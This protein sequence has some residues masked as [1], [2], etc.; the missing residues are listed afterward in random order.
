MVYLVG[1]GP[2]DPGLI[3]VRG[4]EVIAL[5][6]VIIADR[7]A[8]PRLLERARPDAEKIVRGPRRE[9]D[10]A[11]ISALLVE[12]ARAGK[13]V[14][15][16]KGGDPFL[17][18]RGGE[19][20]QALEQ[21]G[22]AYEVVPGVT[23]A[24]AA[25][26]YAG[27]PLTHR[28]LATQVAFATGH[29]ADKAGEARLDWRALADPSTTAVLYMSVSHLE[30]AMAEL[31]R[32]GRAPETPAAI[33]EAG[34]LPAQRTVVGTIADLPAL[35]RRAGVKPPALTVVGE[36]VRFAAAPSWFERRP[37][38]G[39]QVLVTRPAGQADGTVARLEALGARVHLAP[40]IA[41]A[42]PD[43]WQPLDEAVAG[44]DRYRLVALAS[45]NAVDALFERLGR[46]GLDARALAGKVVAAV[47]DKTAAALAARGVR[48]DLVAGEASAEGLAASLAE[49]RWEEEVG[50]GP[51]LL[52][53]AAE[54][55]EA[56]AEALRARGVFVDAPT[57]YRALTAP[58][59]QLQWVGELLDRGALDA[60]TFGSPKSA[61]ALVAALPSARLLER[62][63]V[64]AIG[65][66][67]AEALKRLGVRVDLVAPR[68]SFEA[69]ADALAGA[70]ADRLAA[71]RAGPPV[72]DEPPP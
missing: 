5:A 40:A 17:F 4:A 33:V 52:P 51:A 13:T 25:P 27:I 53:R 23:A 71:R 14:V 46:A 64:A 31:L 20:V 38:H 19:E 68:P 43:S 22:I 48:A 65:R 49:P 44:I 56:L 61:A 3:T 63:F 50:R 72:A 67:T 32:A 16:L 7:L 30:A 28:G 21:A 55:R 58:P 41:I 36:V 1:A 42:P 60:A 9:L 24:M 59:E 54:G 6:D 34:T 69:L 57:A 62:T 37:L 26:A 8:S 35:A 45:A 2:G 70:L 39:A 66:T 29:E 12:R 10:Q 15:R 11:A 47:G 18:G